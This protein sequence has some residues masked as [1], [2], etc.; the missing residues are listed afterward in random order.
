[1]QNYRPLFVLSLGHDYF[2]SGKWSG[3]DYRPTDETQQLFSRC[4][5]VLRALGSDLTLLFDEGRQP[6]M[7]MLA[8][9]TG[10]QLRVALK[11]VVQDRSY[12]NY[13]AIG[14]KL[15]ET[16]P[17]FQNTQ[18]VEA[19]ADGIR[20]S[21]DPF[22]SQADLQPIRDVIGSG[23]LSPAEARV[24]PDLVFDFRFPTSQFADA[25]LPCPRYHVVFSTRTLVWNYFLMG[26][27][28]RE[29]L[30]IVDLD[31]Q[32]EFDFLGAGFKV[33]N[34]E[35]SVFRSKAA[36]P[37]RENSSLR[38]QLRERG[39][40]SGKILLKRLPVAATNFAVQAI[41]GREQLVSNV[42]VNF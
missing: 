35:A 14:A 5:M 40:G 8:E 17:V 18:G 20:L 30:F 7:R 1:M 27:I 31:D 16:L 42:Y 26:S 4:G 32:V 38:F 37:I 9:E 11:A 22:A 36:L 10:G 6:A 12:L 23:L 15:G 39:N 41:D 19:T 13:T 24:P 29:N 3:L 33:A 2:A 28:N 34:R 25:S 21:V